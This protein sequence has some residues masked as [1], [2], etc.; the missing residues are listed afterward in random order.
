M[1]GKT[2]FSKPSLRFLSCEEGDGDIAVSGNRSRCRRCFFA[3]QTSR[4]SCSSGRRLNAMA[5]LLSAKIMRVTLALSVSFWL[6]GASCIWGCNSNAMASP[7]IQP[8]KAVVANSCH[9]TTH[10]CCAKKT[11][12]LVTTLD[13]PSVLSGISVATETTMND[14][15]FAVISSAI[16]SKPSTDSSDGHQVTSAQLTNVGKPVHSL[17][18]HSTPLQAF[19]RGS[20]YLRCCVFLI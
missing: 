15:P 14:C 4:Q 3:P 20:T 8:E 17:R 11:V 1:I 7:A 2:S 18:F 19:N 5:R 9:T 13:Q 6:T 16:V 12:Q 10:H